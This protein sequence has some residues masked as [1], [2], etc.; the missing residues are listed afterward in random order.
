[1][2]IKIENNFIKFSKKLLGT[3]EAWLWVGFGFGPIDN[4]DERVKE[5]RDLMAKYYSYVPYGM[6]V[7]NKENGQLVSLKDTDNDGY[8]KVDLSWWPV[9]AYRMNLHTNAR[10]ESPYGSALNSERR[11]HDVSWAP[12]DSEQWSKEENESIKPFLH[13]EENNAGFSIRILIRPNR[14][15]EVFG[16]NA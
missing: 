1:M 13:K 5:T 7:G 14:T 16:D 15:I 12:I 6:W 11:D 4:D 8:Y 2:M 10:E 3:K 9:G